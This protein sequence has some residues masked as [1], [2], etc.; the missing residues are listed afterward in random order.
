MMNKVE[1]ALLDERTFRNIV[2]NFAT[3]VTIIT[4]K[5][6]DKKPIG[7]TANSFTSLSLNPKLVLFCLDKNS[8]SYE[9]FMNSNAFAVSILTKEQKDLSK[10]FATHGIDRFK[11]VNYFEDITGSPIIS[12]SLAY[13]DCKVNNLVDGGDHTI[14]IGEVL[15]GQEDLT[16]EPLI[17]YHGKYL[18]V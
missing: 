3:G 13:L 5:R 14:I 18:N 17:F 4:T 2:G 8:S 9:T 12:G 11:G 10:Q 16:K 1:N 15:S 6:N 7:F